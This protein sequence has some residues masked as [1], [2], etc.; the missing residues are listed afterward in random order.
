ME[1]EVDK[2]KVWMGWLAGKIGNLVTNPHREENKAC[3]KANA[4]TV[5][6]HRRDLLQLKQN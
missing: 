5:T 2:N 6:G 4:R 1:Q 3:V